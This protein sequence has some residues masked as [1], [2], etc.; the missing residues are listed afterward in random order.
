M[1]KNVILAAVAASTVAVG[2]SACGHTSSPG[3]QPVPP[4]SNCAE[5]ARPADPHGLIGREWPWMS[6]CDVMSDVT[7]GVDQ[8]RADSIVYDARARVV[9]AKMQISMMATDGNKLTDPLAQQPYR[10]KIEDIRGRL[11]SDLVDSSLALKG[12]PP[13]GFELGYVRGND[14]HSASPAWTGGQGR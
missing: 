6:A 9:A 7:P 8:A 12:T 10:A 14:I 1:K 5:V 4:D 13:A 3:A 11:A 2:L